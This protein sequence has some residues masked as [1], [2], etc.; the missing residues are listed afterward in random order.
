[1]A[2]VVKDRVRESTTTTGT[3]TI[4]LGGAVD[5]F[6]SFSVIGDGNTTYYAIYDV[7]TDDWEVGVGTYTASG[8]TLSR[9][10]ILESS[11]AGS[12]VNLA[13]GTKDVYCTY[14]AEKSLNQDDIGTLLQAY[15]ADT[16]K[17][18]DTTANFTGTLQNGGSN[19]VV[20]SDI[21]STVQAYDADTAKYDDTTAN[22]TGTLQ[23]GGSNVVVDTDINVTVQGY[24]ADTAKYDAATANFTGT[25]QNGG[26]NVVVDSDIGSTV[27]GYDAN[28]AKYN[29]ATANFTGTLQNGGSNVLVDSDIGAT[30]TVGY[31]NIP[32]VGTKTSSYTLTTSDV[33]KYVQVGSGGSI[34]VP[35]ST[36]SEGDVVSIFNNT[37]GNVTI[38]LSITTA[39][40]AGENVDIAS[41]TLATRGLVTIFFISATVCV[42][43]GSI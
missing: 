8:A 38:T 40:K 13:A 10:T 9:D 26:S 14:P 1:M 20:D 7:V 41:A 4:T 12:A 15:D 30:G 37:T 43:A 42:L 2:L 23:N 39:Y 27:Q 33:G 36:F 11:N 32:A 17:Y 5:G 25:L 3:G 29:A 16:A 22:F 19:V 18:D 6:Q 34:T 28:T 31:P 24:D 21:G 35:N